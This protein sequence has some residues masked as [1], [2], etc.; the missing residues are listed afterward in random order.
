MKLHALQ[1][2]YL[3]KL[4]Q[5]KNWIKYN[6]QSLK[7]TWER[8]CL[9]LM[10]NTISKH[11]TT[12]WTQH[13]LFVL[14]KVLRTLLLTSVPYIK[15]SGLNILLTTS[16]GTESREWDKQALTAILKQEL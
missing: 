11:K 8:V 16:P 15:V 14:L 7:Y 2:I 3:E 5:I 10:S 6:N 12:N 9:D 13:K 4:K 1:V